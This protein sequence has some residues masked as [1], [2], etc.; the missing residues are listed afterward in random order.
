MWPKVNFQGDKSACSMS[1]LLLSLTVSPMT[2]VIA[3]KLFKRVLDA[4]S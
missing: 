2:K 3:A 4:H 1:I